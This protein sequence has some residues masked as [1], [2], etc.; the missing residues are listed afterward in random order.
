MTH[1]D[2]TTF[3]CSWLADG[4]REVNTAEVTGAAGPEQS[5]GTQLTWS[6]VP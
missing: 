1:A 3:K 4:S 5:N 2:E 6:R